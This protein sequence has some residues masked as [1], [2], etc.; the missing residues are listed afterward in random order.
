VVTHQHLV[1]PHPIRLLYSLLPLHGNTVI[2]VVDSTGRSIR[3]QIDETQYAKKDP[4]LWVLDLT[5]HMAPPNFIFLAMYFAQTSH[6][7]NGRLM[8]AQIS[9]P[10]TWTLYPA[11][12]QVPW[13]TAFLTPDVKGD[14]AVFHWENQVSHMDSLITGF[15]WCPTSTGTQFF[16]ADSF[17]LFVDSSWWLS[18]PMNKSPNILTKAFTALHLLGLSPALSSIQF[19]ASGLDW[20]QMVQALVNIK[21]MTVDALTPNSAQYM[22]MPFGLIASISIFTTAIDLILGALEASGLK[23]EW[24]PNLRYTAL[25]FDIFKQLHLMIVIWIT[26]YS[27]SLAMLA[28]VQTIDLPPSTVLLLNP[29]AMQQVGAPTIVAQLDEWQQMQ[30]MHLSDWL[31]LIDLMLHPA[32]EA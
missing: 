25:V 2:Q 22:S 6:T 3:Q 5:K 32:G 4:F 15:Y 10:L 8:L 27:S 18:C 16:V 26:L 31:Q 12:L 21:F 7:V 23:D 9:V 11:S 1:P 17:K 19:P 24:A 14:T 20:E 13:C 28:E 29:V 30:L